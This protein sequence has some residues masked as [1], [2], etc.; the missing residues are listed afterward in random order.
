MEIVPLGH[1]RSSRRE[2]LDDRWD[3]VSAT[4]EL[5]PATF[6]ERAVLGLGDFSHIEVV[7]VLDRVR[8]EEIEW[9]ARHPRGNPDWPEVGILAQ[10]AKMRPNRLAVSVCPLLAVEGLR[11]SVRGLDAVDGSPVVDVKPYMVEF[12]PR[13]PVRQPEWSHALM[14]DYWTQTGAGPSPSR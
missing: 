6:D 4:I 2:P 8:A 3:E 1:V 13:G 14:R 12:A 10:R 5:D 9:G 7:Y 11:L